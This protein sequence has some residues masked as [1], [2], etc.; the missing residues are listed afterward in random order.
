MS[1]KD[2]YAELDGSTAGKGAAPRAETAAGAVGGALKLRAPPMSGGKRLSKKSRVVLMAIAVG[3][4]G[5]ILVGVMTAGSKPT[6]KPVQLYTTGGGNVGVVKPATAI[7]IAHARAEE[8]AALARRLTQAAH[9]ATATPTMGSIPGTSSSGTE[10]NGGT[11]S[12]P[13]GVAP[14]NE[15]PFPTGAGPGPGGPQAQTPQAQYAA[16]VQRQKYQRLENAEVI[17]RAALTAKPLDGGGAGGAT[18]A[19]GGTSSAS[20]AAGA[21]DHALSGAR[22]LLDMQRALLGHKSAGASTNANESF[23]HRRAE[24]GGYLPDAEIPALGRHELI[25]GSVIPAVLITGINSNLP[26]TVTAEVRQTVYDSFHPNVVLIPQGTRIVGEYSSD[27]GYGQSRVLVAWDELILPNGST[28]N[29]KRMEGVNGQG[30][31]GLRDLVHNHYLR[32]FGS[33]ILMSALGV[34]AQ[35]SQPQNSSVLQA[36]SAGQ[37]AAG[38][39]ADS[40]NQ[41]AAQLLERNLNVAP[42]LIIRPGFTFNVMVNKTMIL[43]AYDARD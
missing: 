10:A 7:M 35:L 27:V 6:G 2:L 33:A 8:Q 15:S 1:E 28:V 34:A 26:G 4:G 14:Q 19:A 3:L 18:G 40:I 22:S 43:P 9:Q 39:A 42:T 25:A 11:P 31:A 17:A 24:A 5:L 20:G 23:L 32:T 12:A 21:L 29:L 37:T 38:A 13:G 36:Q 16:W 30:Q 41:V